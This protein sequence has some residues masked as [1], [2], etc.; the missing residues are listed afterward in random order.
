MALGSAG[1]LIGIDLDFQAGSIFVSKL[2]KL[3]RLSP[4]AL[5]T[6]RVEVCCAWSYYMPKSQIGSIW[7][8]ISP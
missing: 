5:F 7:F 4:R 1:N 6:D 3:F 8:Y 2:H